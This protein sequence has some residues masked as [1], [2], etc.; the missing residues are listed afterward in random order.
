MGGKEGG[1]KMG[2]GIFVGSYPRHY[3]N[4]AFATNLREIL[5]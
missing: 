5:V 1:E 4:G 2:K 3:D